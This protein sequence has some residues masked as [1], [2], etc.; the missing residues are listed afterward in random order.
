DEQ[1]V[2]A[3]DPEALERRLKRAE[4]TAATPVERPPEA[5]AAGLGGVEDAAHL[6]REHVA[7]AGDAAQGLPV[8]ALALARAVHR[9]GVEI[10]E[11][12]R[13]APPGEGD[14]LPP[15]RRPTPVPR[16]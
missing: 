11:P 15:P 4:P 1:D 5:G 7:I 14:G 2:H 3:L 12:Q 8:A 13:E 10:V 16:P 9:R 6:G